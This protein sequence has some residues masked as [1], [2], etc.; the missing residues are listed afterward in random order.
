MGEAA[1]AR[2]LLA[3]QGWLGTPYRHAASLKGE[4]TDCLGLVRGVWRELYG[5]EPQ[6]VPPYRP[7]WAET[8]P[9]ETLLAAAGRWFVPTPLA[10]A[11]PG[12]VVLFRMSPDA[13]VKHCAVL[14]AAPGAGAEGRV[15]HAYWGRAVVESWLGP[16]WRRRVHSAW[17]FPDLPDPSLEE[18]QPWPR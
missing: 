8:G 1:R 6:P 4:A 16:W 17:R 3:A 2:A 10:A 18:T 14:S 7:D 15:I 9:E 12:D 5:A 11:R 13:C